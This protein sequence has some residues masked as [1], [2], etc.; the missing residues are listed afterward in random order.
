MLPEYP[1]NH[2][3]TNK[4][5]IGDVVLINDYSSCTHLDGT[6]IN[7]EDD[8]EMSYEFDSEFIVCETNHR[9]KYNNGYTTYYQNL[10]IANLVTKKHYRIISGH[11][12]LVNN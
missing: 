9:H 12:A 3:D 2:H 11:V 1:N 8:P 6:A 10:I 5:E 4:K 7:Y